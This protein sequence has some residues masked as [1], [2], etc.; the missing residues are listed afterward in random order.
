MPRSLRENVFTEK[1]GGK[2]CIGIYCVVEMDNFNNDRNIFIELKWHF[3]ASSVGINKDY[4]KKRFIFYL[5]Y[6]NEFFISIH[7]MDVQCSFSIQS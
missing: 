7:L 3:Q 5:L 1:N 4:W 6:L 2:K